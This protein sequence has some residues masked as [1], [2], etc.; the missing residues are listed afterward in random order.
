MN[1]IIQVVQHLRP[2]GIET[3][4]LDLSTFCQKNER[5]F[6]ISL[7][8]DIKSAIADWPRLEAY[9]DKI[10]FL[11][12]APGLTPK[13]ILSLMKQFKNLQADTVHSHHI[14]PLL[15]AGIA[16]RLAGIR[17]LIHTEHDAWHLDD[18]RRRKLARCCIKSL[19]PLLVADADTV[20]VNMK[21][22][23]HCKNIHVIQ[24]GIDTERFI[25]G[26]KTKARQLFNLPPDALLIG[27]SGRLEE[28]KGQSILIKAM[29]WL[30][31]NVHLVLAGTGSTENALKHQAF[32]EQ[33]KLRVHFLGRIDDMPAFYQTLDVFC[34]PSFN[35]GL[36]LSPL[37]AQAC[38]IP[39]IVTD[40]GGSSESIC[41]L[42]GSLT[43]EGD[44]R[45]MALNLLEKLQQIVEKTGYDYMPRDFVQRQGNVR[46]MADAY[47]RLRCAGH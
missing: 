15:Y 14:G 11:N 2:G 29:T 32:E 19:R 28:V 37:E 27:C 8:G 4:A 34:L 39:S 10:I 1:T 7:E 26:N 42:T 5:T 24:N 40:V 38:N 20:A 13:L 17:C 41:P 12:K 45:T 6:I 36:P 18:S 25:P 16:A 31:D 44:A 46:L 33:N 35:E 47:A 22:R 43:P 23:L 21:K 3:M 9:K 30:P